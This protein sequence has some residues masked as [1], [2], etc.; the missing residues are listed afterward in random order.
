MLRLRGK[1]TVAATV[2]TIVGI[3]SAFGQNG[4]FTGRE[5]R[6]APGVADSTSSGISG[7]TKITLSEAIERT[8]AND[9]DLR[10]S[11]IQR[12]EA[13]FS[14]RA[15]QGAYDPVFGVSTSR[16]RTV[17]PES[18][19]LS[20]SADGKLTVLQWTGG[21]QLSGITTT[22]ATYSLQFTASKQQNDSLFNT[23]NPQ[24]PTA[25][26]LNVTQPLWR[27]LRF[28]ENRHRILVARKNRQLSNEQLRQRIIE[29][30]TQAVSAYWELDYA[31][32]NLDVQVEAVRL[33]ERQYQS[34][35]RLSD[36]GVLAPVDVVA[37][38]TQVATFEQSL[39]AAQQ[40]LTQA[41]N[42]P[43]KHDAAKSHRP[44][45]ERGAA[46]GIPT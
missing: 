34:N 19:I 14:V 27:G 18:S 29:V 5:T 12:D 6:A 16:T 1:K 9:P 46:G 10:I 4:A 24:Y 17:M 30:V 28:D 26:N 8:L 44:D 15:A 43:E 7:Q 23:L 11:R 31:A 38:Q 22:G 45:V 3:T 33:A 20:G 36:Q 40:L 25:V 32:H 42:N 41:E 39:F 13:G 2:A 35:H 37:A 21:P